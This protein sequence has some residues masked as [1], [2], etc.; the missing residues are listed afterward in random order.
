METSDRSVRSFCAQY[1]SILDLYENVLKFSDF[2]NYRV[3]PSM[4]LFVIT[5]M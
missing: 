1:R 4:S 3:E 5:M 2:S